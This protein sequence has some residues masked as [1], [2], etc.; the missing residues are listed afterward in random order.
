MNWEM[1]QTEIALLK[2]TE[3]KASQKSNERYMR[4]GDRVLHVNNG[5]L[6]ENRE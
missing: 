3:S 5:Y 1:A 2:Y 4:Q 6:K